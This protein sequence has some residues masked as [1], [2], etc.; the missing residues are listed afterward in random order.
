MPV[1]CCHFCSIFGGM[2]C[3]IL[4]NFLSVLHLESGVKWLIGFWVKH[5]DEQRVAHI[6]VVAVLFK[7][8]LQ[9]YWFYVT[10]GTLALFNWYSDIEL[11]GISLILSVIDIICV[12]VSCQGFTIPLDK[13]LAA[14][15]RGLQSVHINENFAKL[16]EALYI[17]DRKVCVRGVHVVH[18]FLWDSHSCCLIP[19]QRAGL[20]SSPF[21]KVPEASWIGCK[22]TNRC[23]WWTSRN[24]ISGVAALCWTD[25]V[26]YERQVT[27][28]SGRS[29]KVRPR[30][31]Q[32]TMRR[33]RHRKHA[34]QLVA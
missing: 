29:V 33:W 25:E 27:I 11:A 32:S 3:W 34:A 6:G 12:I 26:G 13:R 10:C 22:N 15:G 16:A 23:L 7:L 31:F 18:F 8:W 19:S 4:A 9:N 17:A 1:H 30:R 20:H 14:D 2:H 5:P 28:A 21:Q 24:R